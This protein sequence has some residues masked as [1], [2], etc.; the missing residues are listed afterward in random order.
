M[1]GS[2]GRDWKR[3]FGHRASPSPYV[4]FLWWSVSAL[5]AALWIEDLSGYRHR[6]TAISTEFSQLRST[7]TES[8]SNFGVNKPRTAARANVRP[9][10]HNKKRP[11]KQF[12]RYDTGSSVGNPLWA[13]DRTL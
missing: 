12:C 1:H 2:T 3:S 4:I 9:R 10:R 13:N 7:A 5:V 8:Y 11:P 6:K